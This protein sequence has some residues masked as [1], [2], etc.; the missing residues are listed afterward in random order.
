MNAVITHRYFK[1]NHK[2]K[3][4]FLKHKKKLSNFK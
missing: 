1:E 2:T 3:S 4:F